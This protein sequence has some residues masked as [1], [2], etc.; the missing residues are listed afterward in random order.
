M[1]VFVCPHCGKESHIFSHGG[2]R[3][4]A[5]SQEAPFLG[6]IPLVTAIRE[7]SDAG[8]PIVAHSPQSP[9]ARAFIA[10]AEN[11]A[12]LLAAPVRKTPRIVME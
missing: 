7:T 8:T 10:L 1:S 12:R 2:A 5:Q 11:V 4:T 3:K 9:E 6:E